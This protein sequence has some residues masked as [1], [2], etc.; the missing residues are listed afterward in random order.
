[1]FCISVALTVAAVAIMAAPDRKHPE[2]CVRSA[3]ASFALSSNGL[4]NWRVPDLKNLGL[5]NSG[6]FGLFRSALKR[7][8]NASGGVVLEIGWDSLTSDVLRDVSAIVFINP[9]V[10]LSDGE[11]SILKHFVE[12]GGGLLV[13]GDHTDIGGS[14]EPLNA[15]LSFTAIRFNFDSAIPLRDHWQGCLEVRGHPI[16]RGFRD[17]LTLQLAIG[18][19]LAIEEPAVPIVVGRYGFADKGNPLN[20][21]SGAYMGNLI[22][23]RGERLGDIVLVAGQRIGKGRVLV[24]GDTSPFQNGA[25][26]IS[27]R[28]VAQTVAWLAF[29]E[30]SIPESPPGPPQIRFGDQV[31]AIDF[32]LRPQASLALY[33]ESSLGGLANCLARAG[34]VAYPV[35][36][37]EEWTPDSPLLFLVSPTC[38]GR[39][40]ADRLV[41]Y[42]CA[43]GNVILAQGYARRQPCEALLSRLGFTIEN[44]PLGNGEPNSPVE[45]NDAWALSYKCLDAGT[46]VGTPAGAVGTV[47]GTAADTTVIATAFGFPTIATRRCGRGSFTIIGDGRLLLDQNLEGERSASATNVAFISG[48]LERLR[49][50]TRYAITSTN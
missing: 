4:L 5:I 40:E 9:T 8:S 1:M 42:M 38:I 7:C 44:I 21:G 20:S 32:S 30:E 13:L 15:I 29:G 34:V 14:R 50:G 2:V 49:L 41:A 27:Q 48:F 47:V 19:S 17:E 33:R 39:K 23:D 18:A 11:T 36:S 16:T 6:M 43:G 31:A 24:F 12:S 3:K 28:L 22:H 26:L 35:F 46:A 45:H 10:R 37:S 25:L